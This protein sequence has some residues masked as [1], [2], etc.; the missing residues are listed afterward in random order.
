MKFIQ[1]NTNKFHFDNIFSE[2][3]LITDNFLI[4]QIGDLYCESD[5]VVEAHKQ[6]YEL[7]I[8]FISEGTGDFYTD[9]VKTT[10]ERGNIYLSFKNEIHRIS[11]DTF[12][13]LRYY[14]F[15]LNFKTDSPYYIIL[16]HLQNNYS[17]PDNRILKIESIFPLMTNILYELANINTFSVLMIETNIIQ[18]LIS[19]YRFHDNK[20][21]SIY[22]ADLQKGIV[23]N[24]VNY[25]DNHFKTITNL[26]E[27]AKKF[28]YDYSYLTKIFKIVM[29]KTMHTYLQEKKMN[30]AR[31]LLN[32]NYSITQISEI[33]GYSSIHN[34]SRAFKKQFDVSPR[35]FYKTKENKESNKK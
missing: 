27:V 6:E 33:L 15:A 20:N 16:K 17:A 23:Y 19:L 8:S 26:T 11:S 34:F 29:G 24:I 3:P 10:V 2:E 13:N 7:E 1:P 22:T 30:H 5:T 4:Y 31:I 14:Y 35:E 18:I 28:F 12:N 21:L 9:D 32:E 25:I